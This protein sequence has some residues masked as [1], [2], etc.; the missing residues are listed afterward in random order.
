MV[1][2]RCAAHI[3]LY[4]KEIEYDTPI[5]PQTTN[6]MEAEVWADPKKLEQGASNCDDCAE[7]DNDQ[8]GDNEMRSR[9]RQ[10]QS[11]LAVSLTRAKHMAARTR[12]Q[13]HVMRSSDDEDGGTA[14]AEHTARE[15]GC[16]GEEVTAARLASERSHVILMARL[17]G[18][19]EDVLGGEGKKGNGLDGWGHDVGL[20]CKT[21]MAL[22]SCLVEMTIS[23]R[24]VEVQRGRPLGSR[25]RVMELL[26]TT[27]THVGVSQVWDTVGVN[28]GHVGDIG[29]GHSTALQIC[30]ATKHPI[31]DSIEAE[32]DS[33]DD[34][35]DDV[36]H[37]AD[38]LAWE[39]IVP[40]LEK[41]EVEGG[42]GPAEGEV[43]GS[44][45]VIT[46]EVEGGVGPV[47]S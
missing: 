14:N 43:A 37:M 23:A 9:D 40:H 22:A 35:R 21:R 2:G 45:V 8:V 7:G 3:E 46:H 19:Q 18:G 38:I 34:Q 27:S 24:V 30:A 16:P 11:P 5:D 33:N 1:F 10:S 17:D 39:G 6:R 13:S 28:S 15:I 36:P 47:W 32:E 20:F 29:R 26:W 44:E 31:H 42:V 41:L 12:N 25:L 4:D